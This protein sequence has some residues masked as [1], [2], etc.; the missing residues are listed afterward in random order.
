M[1]VVVGVFAGLIHRILPGDLPNRPSSVRFTLRVQ[2]ASLHMAHTPYGA[3]GW[4]LQAKPPLIQLSARP[5]IVLM[6]N[7]LSLAECRVR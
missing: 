3:P 2:R 1:F 6:D 7:V 5:C 4:L